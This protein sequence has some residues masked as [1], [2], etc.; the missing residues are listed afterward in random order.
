MDLPRFGANQLQI[1]CKPIA[2]KLQTNCK[3]IQ[4]FRVLKGLR[5]FSLR[6]VG[7]K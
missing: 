4:K 1:T 5:R 7:D 3:P 6:Q 2:K